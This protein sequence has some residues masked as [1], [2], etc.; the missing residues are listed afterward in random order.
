M[1]DLRISV[2]LAWGLFLVG[3]PGRAVRL[4]G[5]TPTQGAK[6]VARVLGARHLA[7][8][9]VE[10]RDGGRHRLL[11]AAVDWTHAGSGL[12]LALLDRRWRRPALTDATLATA[13]GVSTATAPTTR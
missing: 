4:L 5:G 1:P 11:L 6:T 2:R 13:F 7:Q 8:A 9:A 12:V 3:A 10:A